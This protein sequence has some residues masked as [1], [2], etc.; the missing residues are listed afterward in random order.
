[1]DQ[2]GAVYHL[3]A[4]NY[5]DSYYSYLDFS[6]GKHMPLMWLISDVCSC[7]S[8][9]TSCHA[10]KWGGFVW[11]VSSNWW[12][13]KGNYPLNYD[14][15]WN[16]MEYDQTNAT[17]MSSLFG[18]ACWCCLPSKRVWQYSKG[19]GLN[20]LLESKGQTAPEFRLMTGPL[21]PVDD[22]E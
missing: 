16:S 10:L 2:N 7:S 14:I 18:V 17:Q 19:R 15:S 12:F 9:E 21:Q 4:T 5:L 3:W 1:M 6:D 20:S 13:E 22:W 11:K 8:W